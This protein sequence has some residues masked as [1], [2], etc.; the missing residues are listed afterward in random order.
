MLTPIQVP[1][2]GRFASTKT[3]L[4]SEGETVLALKEAMR[5]LGLLGANAVMDGVW[6]GGLD[7]AFRKW[8]QSMEI[9]ADGVYG[10]Q[11][12]KLLRAAVLNNAPLLGPHQQ[13]LIKKDYAD[14]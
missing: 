5:K 3:K 4:P 13:A 10:E 6:R 2:T 14:Q 8:Q 1:Y 12:W 7:A 9:P 11:E